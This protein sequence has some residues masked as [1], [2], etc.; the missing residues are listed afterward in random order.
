MQDA[1]KVIKDY[2]TNGVTP[3]VIDE[4]DRVGHEIP[5]L[6]A[7]CDSE[8]AAAAFNAMFPP[9]CIDSL[10]SLAKD[11]LQIMADQSKPVE[12]AKDL[13]RLAKDYKSAKSTCPFIKW[14]L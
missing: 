8:E 9:A 3:V 5:T 1:Y 14:R 4:L 10:D 2:E 6:V 11:G 7:V 13:V 12:V